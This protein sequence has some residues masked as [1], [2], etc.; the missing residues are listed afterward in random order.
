[1]YSAVAKF[2]LYFLPLI[3]CVSSLFVGHSFDVVLF[4][5]VTLT[6]GVN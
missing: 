5:Y 2:T 3:L 6:F 1:M 4:R